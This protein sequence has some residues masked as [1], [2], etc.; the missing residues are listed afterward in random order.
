VAVAAPVFRD[1]GSV[2]AAL[3]VSAPAT[4]LTRSRVPAVAAQC[5]AEAGALSAVLGC[6]PQRSPRQRQKEG[7]A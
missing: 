1:G 4:R 7:A 6:Q 5:V 2:V 3:S